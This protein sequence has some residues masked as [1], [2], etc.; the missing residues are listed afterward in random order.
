MK[1][2]RELAPLL[3]LAAPVSL[4][5][6]GGLFMQLVDTVFVG[7]LGPVAIG[8]A[9]VGNAFFAT[10]MIVGIGMSM[11]LD[12][13][14]SH[15]FGAKKLELC[16]RYLVQALY[17]AV[18]NS[19]VFTAMMYFCAGTFTLFGINAE[20]AAAGKSYLQAMCFSLMPFM[21][22]SA[23][24]QYLQAMGVTVPA[25]IIL[26]VANGVNALG[27]WVFIF[28][29]FGF[30]AHGVAG[31]GWS[32][33]LARVFMLAAIAWYVLRRDRRLKLGLRTTPLKFSRKHTL[34]LVKLGL[35]S[36]LTLLFEVGGFATVTMLAGQL[37]AVPLAAHQIVLHL[38]SLTFMI[39]L[40]L[41][42]ATA[43]L[44]GQSLGSGN[45]HRAIAIGWTAIVFGAIF[46]AFMGLLMYAF[47]L[48]LLRIFTSDFRVMQLG[49]ALLLVASL[50]QVSDAMQTIGSGVLR[51][52]GNTKVSMYTNLAGHWLLG[53]P[54][55]YML[56]FWLGWGAHGLWVGLSVGLTVVA[57]GLTY[58]W[59][60]KAHEMRGTL[61]S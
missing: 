25:L 56:C 12:Y 33:V 40:G 26:V 24:R 61:L 45:R 4:S 34:E 32:T 43:V 13:L 27:N 6:L 58:V 51:G 55:G 22:F 47:S 35:P 60:R 59:W 28:G 20:I 14:V 50:F 21:L 18:V 39:P 15:S 30:S 9:S 10:L 2:Y 48:P 19:L 36:A 11:G 29:H 46:A 52:I 49:S 17:L 53:L 8:G 54:V 44:V 5:M 57:L 42:S 1:K 31:S 16:H 23:F 7:R 3:K 37:G 41:S 38:A